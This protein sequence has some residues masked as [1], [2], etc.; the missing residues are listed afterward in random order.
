MLKAGAFDRLR[1]G[2][3]LDGSAETVGGLTG[4]D[5]SVLLGLRDQR[6]APRGINVLNTQ[7]LKRDVAA[8]TVATSLT[9][10]EDATRPR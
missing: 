3:A 9:N 4:W 7:S 1:T 2:C 5:T 10:V 6:C 8:T